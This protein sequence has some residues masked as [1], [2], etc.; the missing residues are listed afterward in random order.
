MKRV[1]VST[2]L[3]GCSSGGLPATSTV[4][5]AGSGAA[6]TRSVAATADRG[7]RTDYL[8]RPLPSWAGA[9]FNP[10]TQPVP[11]VL[12]DGGHIVA[13]VWQSHNPLT[14]PRREG[15]NNK[16]LWISRDAS[17][18]AAPLQIQATLPG[19]DQRATYT[20]DLRSGQSVIDL[21]A[22][23]CWSFDLS[24]GEHQDHLRMEYAP[25]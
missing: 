9:A 13:V 17:S 11:Y 3:A 10:P 15:R 5:S 8:P 23:G 19:S 20:V 6:G 18:V 25:G 1:P 7:C 4:S 16:I 14:V 22:P 21:P 12:G 24:W 2:V